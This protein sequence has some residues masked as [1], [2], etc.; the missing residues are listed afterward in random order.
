MYAQNANEK[1]ARLQKCK[2]RKQDTSSNIY[3]FYFFIKDMGMP[4][5]NEYVYLHLMRICEILQQH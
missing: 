2:N 1:K 3:L 5:Y 4:G